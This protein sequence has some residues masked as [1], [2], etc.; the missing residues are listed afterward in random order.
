MDVMKIT[1]VAID[2]EVGSTWPSDWG[3]KWYAIGNASLTSG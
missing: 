1:K 2:A 3:G